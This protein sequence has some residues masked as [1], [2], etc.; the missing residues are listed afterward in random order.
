MDGVLIGNET[1]LDDLVYRVLAGS[2]RVGEDDE[3]RRLPDGWVGKLYGRLVGT[4]L[5]GRVGL[6]VARCLT[7]SSV[8]ARS[9]ALDFFVR[10][11]LRGVMVPGFEHI[12]DLV[13]GDREKFAQVR[14]PF[15]RSSTLET[16]LL[17]ALSCR[18]RTSERA[19]DLAKSEVLGSYGE[20]TEH[21]IRELLQ[22]APDW[23]VE[24]A[25]A[26]A[27]KHER[28]WSRL[29]Y[30]AP[31]DV[32]G[33]LA[34]RLARLPHVDRG[35]LRHYVEYSYSD[36]DPRLKSYLKALGYDVAV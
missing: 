2:V 31:L 21:L 1:D 10:C 30:H 5:E 27:A 34:V 16:K 24:N 28:L 11:G 18:I 26:I 6:A 12:E 19:R 32:R 13:A 29:L 14:D 22:V 9:R 23:I 17:Q 4:G 35:T 36:R 8:R 25:E 20:A 15:A 33:P 7:A 3:E